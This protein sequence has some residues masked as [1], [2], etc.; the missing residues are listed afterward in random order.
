M[1]INLRDNINLL[2]NVLSGLHAEE[3]TPREDTMTAHT[4]AIG[5]QVET[6]QELMTTMRTNQADSIK[7][8]VKSAISFVLVKLKAH[9]PNLNLQPIKA[10]FD[11]P[12]AEA[13]RLMGE[14]Q[15]ISEEVTE[16]MQLR[17]PLSE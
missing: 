11:C 14:M 7:D 2:N 3:I 15:S 16:D 6:L 17:S 10:D 4:S 5:D 8:A 13:E 9:D 12:E 1:K